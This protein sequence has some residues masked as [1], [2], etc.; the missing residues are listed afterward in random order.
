MYLN[1]YVVHRCSQSQIF[2]DQVDRSIYLRQDRAWNDLMDLI[3]HASLNSKELVFG[4]FI[5]TALSEFESMKKNDI[6]ALLRKS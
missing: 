4:Y 2:A 3:L 1:Q 5:S 6:V